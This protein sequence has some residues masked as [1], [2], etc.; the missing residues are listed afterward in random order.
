MNP[1]TI[2]F[3]TGRELNALTEN[4]EIFEIEGFKVKQQEIFEKNAQKLLIGSLETRIDKKTVRNLGAILSVMAE[5]ELKKE[6]LSRNQVMRKS[7]LSS[8]IVY[9]LMKQLENKGYIEEVG[10]R[11]S[12]RGPVSETP[13]YSFTLTG[14]ILAGLLLKKPFL[15]SRAFDMLPD[16]DNPIL[17]F[18]IAL[19][20]ESTDTTTYALLM[21]ES[22]LKHLLT[23]ISKGAFNPDEFSRT[24]LLDNYLRLAKKGK[25]ASESELGQ[26]KKLQEIFEKKYSALDERE[27]RAIFHWIKSNLESM[28]LNQLRGKIFYEYLEHTRNS[29]TIHAFCPE[30][31]KIVSVG[32]FPTLAADHKCS[33]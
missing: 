24:I 23:T 19:I 10:K 3:N 26:G 9:S 4:F 25:A 30:C 28:F 27:M 32:S 14:N 6:P 2:V 13:I 21:G 33:K 29:D 8:S 1:S 12:E 11:K 15:M 18:S 31:Q 17:K 16:Q 20:K 22:V 7:I 5:A